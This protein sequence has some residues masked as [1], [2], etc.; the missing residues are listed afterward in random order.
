MHVDIDLYSGRPNPGWSLAAGDGIELM[1]RVAALPPAGGAAPEDADALGYRG[2]NVDVAGSDVPVPAPLAGV[3]ALHVGAAGV[4]TVSRRAG[5]PER[6]LDV[7]CALARWLLERARGQ[8]DEDVRRYALD[9][10]GPGC[11]PAGR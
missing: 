11:A 6:R 3:T 7:G 5:Q 4:V 2:L 10:Q 8:V 1:R 9:Q